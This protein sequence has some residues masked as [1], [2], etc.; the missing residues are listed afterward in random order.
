M[1]VAVGY[2]T[3]WRR[4]KPP[5]QVPSRWLPPQR[6]E[7]AYTTLGDTGMKHRALYHPKPAKLNTHI[8]FFFAPY[9][10]KTY[11]IANPYPPLPKKYLDNHNLTP[12]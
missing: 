11:P 7:S 10:R 1:P 12:L 3:R 8:I 4:N 9:P 2:N 5:G 6:L